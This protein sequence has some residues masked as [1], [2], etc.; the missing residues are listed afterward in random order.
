MLLLLHILGLNSVAAAAAAA[1]ADAFDV[2]GVKRGKM[3]QPLVKRKKEVKRKKHFDRHQCDRKLVVKPS[4]R[5][6]KGIDGRVRR[7]FK[8]AIQMP[9]IGYGTNKKD[10]HVLPNGF[11]KVRMPCALSLLLR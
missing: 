8:G 10:R 2:G 4:W 5:K 9:N 7:R 6:P 1:S 3:V 11:K